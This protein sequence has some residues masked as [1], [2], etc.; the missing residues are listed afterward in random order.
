MVIRLSTQEEDILVTSKNLVQRDTGTI[1]GF[2]EG[3]PKVELWAFKCVRAAI[4]FE[5]GAF[6]AAR[7][8][9]V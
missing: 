3:R 4:A 5:G 7:Q 9:L 8:P 6:S 1:F 2:L